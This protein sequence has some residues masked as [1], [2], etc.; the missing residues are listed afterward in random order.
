MTFIP[1]DQ[2]KL[3]E[4][5]KALA[6]AQAEFGHIEKNKT[7]EIRPR[8]KPAYS[9]KYADL[10]EILGKIKPALSKHG[11]TLL[12]PVLPDEAGV[13]WLITAVVHAD[14]AALESRVLAP[15]PTE[16]P[17]VYG[18]LLSFMRRYMVSAFFCLAADDDLDDN[19]QERGEGGWD[20]ERIERPARAAPARKSAAAK[21]AS[22]AA[23]TSPAGSTINPG[24]VKFLNNKLAALKLDND[25]AM[26]F[27]ERMDIPGFSTD[28]SLAKFAELSHELDRMRDA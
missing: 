11:L 1:S 4:L 6:L 18:G 8:E 21:T 20:E 16:D 19:G 7:V 13:S 14:G 12:Q 28:I 24:Q 15:S 9:F 23:K 26:E 22:A 3:P 2:S 10:D 27:F 5:F 17:K 25:A